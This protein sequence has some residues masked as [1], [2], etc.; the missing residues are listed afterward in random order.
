MSKGRMDELL[1]HEYDGIREYDNP[2]PAWWNW[3]F[4][5]SFVF[6]VGYFFHYHIGH[7]ESLHQAYAAKEAEVLKVRE[8]E[9]LA[10]GKVTEDTL[11]KVLADASSVEAGHEKYQAF[12]A[13]CHGKKGEGLI[14]PNL[15]DAFWIHGKGRLVD[16]REVVATG[17]AAKGMPAWEKQMSP[18]EL[19][20]VVAF[21]GSIR[22]KN[23]KGKAPQGTEIGKGG[24]ADTKAAPAEKADGHEG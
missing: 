14:G 16:I 20:R 13:A 7:G 23:E 21:V 1:D 24:E 10:A 4:F 22:G 19:M 9:A 2:V 6:S 11:E 5:G 12:C 3:I 8:K 17:V 18:E 15:T